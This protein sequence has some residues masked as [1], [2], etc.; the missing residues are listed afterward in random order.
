MQIEKKMMMQIYITRYIRPIT[1]GKAI[2]PVS[3][4][5]VKL[6]WF[7]DWPIGFVVR[8][9]DCKAE[10][11]WFARSAGVFVLDLDVNYLYMFIECLGKNINF[12]VQYYIIYGIPP[13]GVDRL[14]SFR[15]NLRVF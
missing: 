13:P 5:V 2:I 8:A 4:Q 6:I 3:L 12:L 9:P 10:G 14:G 15:S 7:F 11:R 1:P